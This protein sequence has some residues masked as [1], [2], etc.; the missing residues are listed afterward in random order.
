MQASCLGDCH[1]RFLLSW[2]EGA[3]LGS[4]GWHADYEQPLGKPLGPAVFSPK[5]KTLSRIFDS[6]TKVVFTPVLPPRFLV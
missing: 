1:A 3:M 4:N 6:K 2:E 5:T